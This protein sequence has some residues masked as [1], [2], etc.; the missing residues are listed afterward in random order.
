MDDRTKALLARIDD[1]AAESL[2]DYIRDTD[3]RAAEARAGRRSLLLASRDMLAALAE[4]LAA[5]EDGTPQCH[6]ER[7]GHASPA[8]CVACQARD[9]IAKATKPAS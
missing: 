1:Q 3:D 7:S 8:P 9:A 2:N 4:L 6:C 5:Y